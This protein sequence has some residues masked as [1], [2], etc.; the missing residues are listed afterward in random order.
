[1]MPILSSWACAAPA[2]SAAAAKTPA[3]E[4][5]F[6]VVMFTTPIDCGALARSGS[7]RQPT[8]GARS[9]VGNAA[10]FG[11]RAAAPVQGFTAVAIQTDAPSG[12]VSPCCRAARAAR[13]ELA[14]AAIC[15]G[16]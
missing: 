3:P 6:V 7:L 2:S 14:T 8:L 12:T 10:D 4:R 9:K 11:L 15:S 1:M 13:I 16:A 5:H